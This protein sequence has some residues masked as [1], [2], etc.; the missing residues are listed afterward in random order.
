MAILQLLK[1]PSVALT[2][3]I[4]VNLSQLTD[5]RHDLRGIATHLIKNLQHA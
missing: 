5:A 3:E 2:P 1:L 4:L